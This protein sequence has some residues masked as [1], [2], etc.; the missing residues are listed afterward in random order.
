[1][2]A[3]MLKVLVDAY[4]KRFDILLEELN[5]LKSGIA[6]REN[7]KVCLAHG[8]HEF[9]KYG[10]CGAERCRFCGLLKSD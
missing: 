6:E 8:G 9:V 1:M 3:E 10:P 5:E 2:D 4:E 7:E